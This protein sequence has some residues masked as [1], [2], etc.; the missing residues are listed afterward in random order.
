MVVKQNETDVL[1]GLEVLTDELQF[2]AGCC[3]LTLVLSFL[4]KSS[5]VDHD[6]IVL[7]SRDFNVQHP[8][9]FI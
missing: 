8:S 1:D 5:H 3:V 6:D 4:I 9:P 7:P 2:C